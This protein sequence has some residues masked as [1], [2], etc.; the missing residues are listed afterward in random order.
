MGYYQS[1]SSRVCY[2]QVMNS[3]V[4][5]ERLYLTDNIS[6]KIEKL[7]VVIEKKSI[8]IDERSPIVLKFKTP[9]FRY[10]NFKIKII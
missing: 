2:N 6:I 1:K 10:R 7:K 5:N 8:K 9:H 4:T 3:N